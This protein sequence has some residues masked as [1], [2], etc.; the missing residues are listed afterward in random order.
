MTRV[1]H[2][3]CI[4]RRIKSSRQKTEDGGIG[5][6]VSCH[7]ISKS[8]P[9]AHISEISLHGEPLN[10][11]KDFTIEES[12][13]KSESKILKEILVRNNLKYFSML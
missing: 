8:P 5:D 1:Y 3:Q 11:Y 12:R 4:K 13:G 2:V 9:L 7:P 10:D 6:Q